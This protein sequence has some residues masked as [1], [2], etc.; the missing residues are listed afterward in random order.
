[1]LNWMDTDGRTPL[2][3]ACKE[4]NIEVIKILLEAAANVNQPSKDG[5][6]P[7]MEAI[8]GKL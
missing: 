7:L 6:T 8:E 4:G 1:M 3:V 2:L 5:R